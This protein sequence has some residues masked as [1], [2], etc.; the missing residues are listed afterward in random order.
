MSQVQRKIYFC[1]LWSNLSEFSIP[2]LLE[3]FPPHLQ[4]SVVKYT[5]S[6]EGGSISFGYTLAQT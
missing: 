2:L 6:K 1:C 3:T 5:I 4:P